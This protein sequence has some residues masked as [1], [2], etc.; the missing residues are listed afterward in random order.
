MWVKKINIYTEIKGECLSA[1]T[2]FYGG[3][4]MNITFQNQTIK[5]DPQALNH[6]DRA[7]LKNIGNTGTVRNPGKAGKSGA[8]DFSLS[9][10]ES[11]LDLSG[12]FGVDRNDRKKAKSLTDLQQEASVTDAGIR[13]DYMTVMSNTMSTEDYQKLSEDGFDF[14]SMDQGE[15]V[16]IVDKIKAE[17]ARSGQ[18]IIGYT[19]D[20]DMDTLAAAV[21]SEALA[22]SLAENFSAMDVPMTEENIGD[23]VKAWNMAQQ[24]QVPSQD[25]YEYM[26]D[27]E[28]E[29][30]LWN[31]YLA[32]NSGAGSARNPAAVNQDLSYLTDEKIKQQI[33]QVL[34]QG[35]YEVNEESRKDAEWLLERELPLTAENIQR[36]Q[37]M[38]E[39]TL[40]VEA[41]DF[42]KAAATAIADGKDPLHASLKKSDGR[43]G[44]VYEKAAQ[45]LEYYNLH[46]SEDPWARKQ[47]EEIRLRMTAETNVK[48][49]KS[50]FAIDTAPME[51]LIEALREA[52][53]AVANG[54]FPQDDQAVA[55]Y[56]NWN[57]TNKAVSDI[58]S[59]PAQ[60]LGTI[61]IG[62]ASG[63]DATIFARFHEE[64]VAL[65]QAYEKAGESYETLMTA[66]RADLGDSMK[67]AF[68]NADE[69]I[70]ELGLEPV[71]ENERA[72]RILGYNR[73]EISLENIERVKEAD[74]MVQDLVRK[75]TPAATLKM[76][77]DGIN[78]L[79]SSFDS[80]NEY[81]DNLPEDYGNQA[82]SYSRYLYGLEKNN[83]ITKEERSSYIGVYRLL[84]QIEKKD[85]AAI[86]A[87]LSEQAE[88][89]FSNLLSAVRSGKFRHMDVVA[90]DE[91]GTLRDLVAK[92]ESASISDQIA[93][94]YAKEQL[95]ELRTA[96]ET[97]RATVDMLEKS[98][99]PK[100]AG[101][102]LA[103]SKL[104]K[105]EET[106]YK[107]L[108]GRAE[109][110]SRLWEK[111]SDKEDFRAEYEETIEDLKT[112]AEEETF[113]EAESSLDV[114]AFRLAH[115]QLSIM[116]SLSPKE[117]YFIPMDIGEE[118][119]LVHLTFE[120]GGANKGGINISVDMG[121]ESRVEAHLQVK[122]DRVEGFLLGKTSAEVTKLQ[123]ASDI[124]YNLINE[125]A[126]VD[127]KAEQLPVVTSDN[128]KMTRMSDIDSREDGNSP[129]NGM[130][131]HVAKLFLQAIR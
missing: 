53:K 128:T 13:Q 102:L 104:G 55:K 40:P 84:H 83:Q 119:A 19:D 57:Q 100:S 25:T 91:L 77:R 43:E 5:N 29:P 39:V 30:E 106:P 20:I 105:N 110:A 49:L 122:E 15:A 38:R 56:E 125:D 32:Q 109:S 58:P 54:Y 41:D 14:S 16:N 81:F 82:E 33:D 8:A 46:E 130:L 108:R 4:W 94:G 78:P 85:G 47:L 35:G 50:G 70:R 7:D 129:D 27:N 48:L 131:Y 103:A 34:E 98:E 111:L 17:L 66:P 95:S 127:L 3:I 64:G 80:L 93:R 45:V 36:L 22:R 65:K 51:E 117:E 87:V 44:S 126:S 88:M 113:V 101:N 96:A 72:V 124:F 112:E 120:S 6:A 9:A 21:G 37:D 86:G 107:T 92:G 115:R 114:R 26:I 28:L 61:R 1:L 90:N 42:A 24:L 99:L 123:K 71:Q 18:Q 52:E 11:N 10:A 73:M 68:S 74:A 62:A 60:L 2:F 79:E 116:G 12:G 76:I 59:L 23:T 97:E 63:E 118:E 67:K 31:F 69:L 121:D 89:Q 75:M